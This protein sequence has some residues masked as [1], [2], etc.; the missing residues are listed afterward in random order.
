MLFNYV[1]D[2][3][4]FAGLGII[5]GMSGYAV[6]SAMTTEIPARY[7]AAASAGAVFGLIIGY[8]MGA[9]R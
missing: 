9:G 5:T 8:V 6:A 7:I 2:M 4:I 1:T 3:L